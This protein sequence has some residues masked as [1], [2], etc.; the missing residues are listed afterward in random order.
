MSSES[1]VQDSLKRALDLVA[2]SSVL[3]VSFP[4]ILLAALAV[5]LDSTG[6]AL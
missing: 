1:A 5:R 6:P 2:A 3:L 4:L